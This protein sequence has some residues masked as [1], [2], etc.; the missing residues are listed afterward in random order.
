[1]AEG[2]SI[3]TKIIK[4]EIPS[5]KVYEDDKTLAFL[6]ITPVTAGHTLVVPKHPV[7]HLWDM[8][9]QDYIYLMKIAK[10]IANRQRQVLKPKRVGIT[11]EGFG[12]PDHVHIHVF[13][14]DTGIEEALA[15]KIPAPT[16][17]ELAAMA[18][19]LRMS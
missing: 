2:D 9:D 8:D 6:D 4:G 12:V 19:K 7:D 15:N 16:Q 1:M 17:E 13:P 14:L 10:K 18:E 3:F 11:V 5:H